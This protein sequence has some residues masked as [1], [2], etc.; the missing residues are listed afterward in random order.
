[1]I[2]FIV[3]IIGEFIIQLIGEALFALGYRSLSEPFSKQ[4]NPWLAALGFGLF[5]TILGGISL[6]VLPSNLTHI[7]M[8]RVANLVVTPLLVGLCMSIIGG[9]RAKRGGLVLPIDRFWYGYLFALTV[10]LIRFRFAR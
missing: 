6:L 9:W 5:G 2:E 4:P 3:Q 7:G 1:M 10:A 8:P